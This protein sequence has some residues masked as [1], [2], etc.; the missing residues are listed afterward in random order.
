MINNLTEAGRLAAYEKARKWVAGPKP[1]LSKIESRPSKYPKQVMRLVLGLCLLLLIAAFIPSAIRLYRSGSEEFCRSFNI[2]DNQNEMLCNIVGVSTVLLAETGSLVF[3]LALSVVQG[4]ARYKIGKFN[5]DLVRVFLWTSTLAS[6]LIAIVGNA[7][8]GKPWKTQIVFDYL[9]TFVPPILVL[10]VGYVLKD[11][12]LQSIADR[13]TQLTEYQQKLESYQ[14]VL[15]YP[16]DSG[17]WYKAYSKALKEAIQKA[18]RSRKEELSALSS[19]EWE[20]LIMQEIREANWQVTSEKMI[21]AEAESISIVE[22][23]DS[24]IWQN[25]SGAWSARIPGSET[26]LGEKYSTPGR[27][28]GAVKIHQKAIARKANQNGASYE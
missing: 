23:A 15:D 13:Y 25:E 2:A 28:R 11:L 21:Q 5:I 6:V 17:K 18:N 14:G 24:D 4:V 1:R 12:F 22:I 8:I 16:E 9:V 19:K 26:V 7:H 10:S 3:I 27:A 20:Y